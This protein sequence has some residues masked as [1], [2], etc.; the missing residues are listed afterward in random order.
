MHTQNRL[1]TALW[2]TMVL[3]L[4][5]CGSS[6]QIG[7]ASRGGPTPDATLTGPITSGLRGHALWDS[8]FRLD[9][10]GYVEE[11]YFITGVATSK[12]ADG[13]DAPFTT[14]FI[15]RRP[16]N[17]SAFNGTVVLDWVNVTA[18]FE[19]AV[20]TLNSQQHF[21]R[22][23]YAY[24]HVSAQAAGVCCLPALTPKVWDPVRYGP[25]DHPGDDYAFSML[26]QIARAIRAP[27]G[28][29][30]MGGLQVEKV[31]AAGQS[32]SAN[33]LFEFVTEGHVDPSVIDGVLIHSSIGR[34]FQAPPPVP[35]LHLL[36]D[37]EAQP[38]GPSTTDNVVLW[39]VAGSSH[40]DFHVG[41]QQVL[42][43]GLR[44]AA[45][46]PQRPASAYFD[47]LDVAGSF[48][49]QPNPLYAACILAG[50]SFPMRYAVNAAF[51][52]LNQWVRGGPRPPAAERYQFDEAGTL[53]TDRF[54]NALG[55]IRLPPVD[56]PVARYQSTLCGLGGIT[57]P[58]T[59]LEL[60]AEY[61]SHAAYVCAMESATAASIAE[62][63]LLPADAEDLM[64]RV[65]GAANRFL[66]PGVA[67]CGS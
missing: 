12:Q 33:Q 49:D 39:E 48:G 29:D 4:T 2:L 47:L 52:H 6:E 34:V 20:D 9:E 14:R 28:L 54:G 16:A 62:G 35:V 50:A 51:H 46:V 21:L 25:L 53:A 37:Y 61:G 1:W 19:N 55:G 8:W 32:Q 36:S 59:S 7:N 24:V 56:V 30:P 57:V 27:Q 60:G 22:E 11:E 66:V 13:A 41:Y 18:Q 10:L 17:A 23:G 42:G 64:Q 15:L 67:G 44:A 43:Q 3:T 40:Q 5:A 31:L 63:F 65:R 45:S 26:N 38:E 58:F